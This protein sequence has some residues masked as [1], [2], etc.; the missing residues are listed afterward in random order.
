MKRTALALAVLLTAGYLAA[1]TL[2]AVD[3]TE[4][5]VLTQ[6]GR[7]IR[8]VEEAGLTFKLPDPVQTALRLDRRLQPLDSRLREYLT[9]DKKNLVAGSLILWR[10]R[11]PKRFI[12]SVKD[13]AGAE[14]RLADL[15][16]SELGSAIGSYPLSAFLN[17]GEQGTRIPELAARVTKACQQQA[18]SEFGVEILDVRLRRLGFPEQNQQSVY[19]RMKAERERIAKK[20]RAEGEEEAAKIRSQTDRTVRELLATAY[21]DAQV[22]SGHGDAEA[23]RIYGLA[24]GKAPAF[25]KLTRTLEAY[26]K[27]LDKDTT[28][29]LSADSPLFRYLESPPEER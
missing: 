29:I 26:R 3:E 6:F 9:E 2:V 10:I 11:E 20:Y 7:P 13:R 16:D 19:N 23:M 12:Q 14:Q 8:V 18:L 4:I 22:T 1:T 28:L 15:V 25:Y 5:V 17:P 21:R 24:Y 27:F